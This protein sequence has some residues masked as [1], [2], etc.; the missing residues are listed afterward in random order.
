MLD[1][2]GGRGGKLATYREALDLTSYEQDDR[3]GDA[4]RRIGRRQG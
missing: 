2:K 3:R 1:E 4:D